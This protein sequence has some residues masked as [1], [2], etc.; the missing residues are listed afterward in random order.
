MLLKTCSGVCDYLQVSG[1]DM[2]FVDVFADVRV[3]QE[4]CHIELPLL[5]SQ[6]T[7]HR[8]SEGPPSKDHHLGHSHRKS[9]PAVAAQ[10]AKGQYCGSLVNFTRLLTFSMSLRTPV[11][12]STVL[13]A[14]DQRM[15][16]FH[17]SLI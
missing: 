1:V 3:P 5:T 8:S 2:S 10:M 4:E 16:C 7:G 17:D 11:P 9:K 12:S 15:R 14:R 6:R 13:H